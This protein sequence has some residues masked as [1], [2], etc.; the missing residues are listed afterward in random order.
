MNSNKKKSVQLG[1]PHGTAA[2]RLRKAIMFDFAKRLELDVCYQCGKKIDSV[3][4]LSVE[5]KEPWLDS[6]DPVG[7]FFDLGNIAFSHLSCNCG[8]ARQTKISVVRHGSQSKYSYGCRC[9]LCKAAHSEYY[10][11]KT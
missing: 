7:K 4:E 11:P 2:N 1:M 5:H 10:K 8:S 3:D 6:N 9:D